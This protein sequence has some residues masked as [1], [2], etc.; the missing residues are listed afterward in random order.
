MLLVGPE[1]LADQLQKAATDVLLEQ[2]LGTRTV[3]PATESIVTLTDLLVEHADEQ[4]LGVLN[5]ELA[6]DDQVVVLSEL[7]D[8]ASSLW[9]ELSEWRTRVFATASDKLQ[10]LAKKTMD[11]AG[12][13]GVSIEHLLGRLQRRLV[14]DLVQNTVLAPFTVGQGDKRVALRPSELTVSSTLKSSPS[15]ASLDLL[16]TVKLLS[17]LLNMELKVDVKYTVAQEG[18]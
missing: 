18:R 15:L 7:R 3:P 8:H 5:Q 17:G 4:A 14:G 6:T 16:G 2:E 9:R 13:L 12:R 10:E 11:L 1:E